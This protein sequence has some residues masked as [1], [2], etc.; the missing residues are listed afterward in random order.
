MPNIMTGSQ[1]MLKDRNTA[2]VI[3]RGYEHDERFA[4]KSMIWWV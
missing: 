1:I 4:K 3:T 2:V